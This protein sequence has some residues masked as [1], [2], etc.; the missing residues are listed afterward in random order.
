MSDI[1]ENQEEVNAFINQLQHDINKGVEKLLEWN[2]IHQ[3]GQFPLSDETLSNFISFHFI[4]RSIEDICCWIKVLVREPSKYY[5]YE[6]VYR[7][8]LRCGYMFV[9]YHSQ[10]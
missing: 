5:V 4:N 6:E 1:T 3:R 8:R 10:I 2:Q 7:R 9:E